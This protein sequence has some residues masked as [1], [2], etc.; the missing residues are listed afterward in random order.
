ML[1]GLK[2]VIVLME[3]LSNLPEASLLESDSSIHLRLAFISSID[4][5]ATSKKLSA[6][7]ASSAS[8][9]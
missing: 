5:A 7:Q 2:Y 8:G 4:L 1:I 6:S 9:I 3:K